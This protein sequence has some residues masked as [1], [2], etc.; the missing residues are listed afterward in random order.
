M[1]AAVQRRDMKAIIECDLNFHISLAESCG[2][3]LLVDVLRR[4]L[5]T[6]LAFIQMRVMTV[7]RGRKRGAGTCHATSGSSNLSGKGTPHLQGNTY[8]TAS[9]NSRRRLTPFGRTRV[10]LF[11]LLQIAGTNVEATELSVVKGS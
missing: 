11:V 3:P 9:R 8:N 1:N 5:I 6:T 2:N 10:D 4:L 7:V